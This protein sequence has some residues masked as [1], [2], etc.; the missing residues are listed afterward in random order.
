MRGIGNIDTPYAVDTGY[1][2]VIGG[3]SLGGL[4]GQRPSKK[5][6]WFARRSAGGSAA[7][8]AAREQ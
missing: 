6:F 2:I 1:A 8:A 4:E 5:T 7:R 3:T